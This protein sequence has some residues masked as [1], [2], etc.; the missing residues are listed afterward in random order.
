[1]I[2][3]ARPSQNGIQVLDR[4]YL[5]VREPQEFLLDCEVYFSFAKSIGGSQFAHGERIALRIR[6]RGSRTTLL[7]VDRDNAA[8]PLEGYEMWARKPIADG[9]M[10]ANPSVPLGLTDWRGMMDIEKSELP[11]RLIYVKTERICW[12]GSQWFLATKR[13][14]RFPCRRD[15]KRLEAVAF[16]KGLESTVMDLVARREILASRIRQRLAQGK[17]D[18]AR[19]L[20][21]ENEELSDQSR[22]GTDAGQ[23]RVGP[24]VA[25]QAGAATDRQ[26]ADGYAPSAEQV[27]QS[28]TTGDA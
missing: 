17:R 18:E 21:E 9:D 8:V 22:P 15:D 23:S 24:G 25:G 14:K 5:L 2:A 7:L 20:L 3:A 19:A 4:T 10:A 1:M 16:V 26:V 12:P 11:L 27:S 28:R 6:S 13:S